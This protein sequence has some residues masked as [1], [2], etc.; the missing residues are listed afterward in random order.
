MLKSTAR[1]LSISLA[2]AAF[3]APAAFASPIG[4]DP[5]P[6]PRIVHH[7]GFTYRNGS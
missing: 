5:E 4:T 2:L 6:D 7:V 1:K 3:L